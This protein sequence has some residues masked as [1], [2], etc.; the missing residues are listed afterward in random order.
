MKLKGGYTGFASS[1]SLSVRLSVRPSVRP[2]VDKIVSALYLP[3][4]SPD[5]FHMCTSYQATSEG[6]CRV[7]II[8]KLKNMNFWQFFVICNFDFVLLWHGIWYESIV[9]VIMGRRGYSQNAVVLVEWGI[10]QL[11]SKLHSLH[12][13]TFKTTS[14]SFLR[15]YGI[16]RYI[17]R[18]LSVYQAS[19]IVRL[20]SLRF[21][22][23]GNWTWLPD[24]STWAE[25]HI[26]ITSTQVMVYHWWIP[27]ETLVHTGSR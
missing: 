3:K 15:V 10:P 8:A 19:W 7:K 11:S 5:P 23:K 13:G 24:D 18:D 1:V 21:S 4:Y 17:T 22:H 26:P 16:T 14:K 6:V 20:W 2:S 27:C 25:F 9:W 12:D